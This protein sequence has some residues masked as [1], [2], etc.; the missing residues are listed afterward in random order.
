M[1]KKDKL[2][3]FKDYMTCKDDK[4]ASKTRKKLNK[5]GK[6]GRPTSV[7]GWAGYGP[8]PNLS[9]GGGSDGGNGSAGGN[10]G[11]MGEAYNRE[12]MGL[13]KWLSDEDYEVNYDEDAEEQQTKKSQAKALYR[14]FK[15]QGLTKQEMVSRFEEV[16]GVTNSTAISY[17]ERIA[18]EFG[19]TGN[20]DD[21][22]TVGMG[23]AGGAGELPG[24]AGGAGEM[25]MGAFGDADPEEEAPDVM[26]PQE[27]QDP[28]RQGTI[29]RVKNAHLVYK[30]QSDDGTFEE[31]WIYKQGDKFDD[32][33]EIRRDILAGTDIPV[34]KTQSDDKRQQ[35]DTWTSGNVQM[36]RITGLT[37]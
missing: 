11:G 19:D 33:L 27:W 20:K 30:R 26:E 21:P 6:G 5:K 32:E 24:G 34:N 7:H 12:E 23:P 9:G 10:G 37:N 14:N 25:G 4:L 8:P 28:N 22:V 3:S 16:L 17:Y 15:R 31:L 18:K 1:A 36:L 2:C 35:S 13:S 29:R